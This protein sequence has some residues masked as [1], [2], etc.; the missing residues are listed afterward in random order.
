MPASRAR[1]RE[2][3]RTRLDARDACDWMCMR[4]DVHASQRTRHASQELWLDDGEL[5]RVAC[6]HPGYPPIYGCEEV[7]RSTCTGRVFR[8]CIVHAGSV[9]KLS[10]ALNLLVHRSKFMQRPAEV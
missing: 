4:S 1:G 9:W 6:A 5:P 10:R 3:E 7:R 8:T 2:R